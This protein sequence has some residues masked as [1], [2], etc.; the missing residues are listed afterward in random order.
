MKAKTKITEG[1]ISAE[2]RGYNGE[3][4]GYLI[5]RSADGASVRIIDEKTVELNYRYNRNYSQ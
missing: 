3:L 4:Y 1:V 5:Y 2:I